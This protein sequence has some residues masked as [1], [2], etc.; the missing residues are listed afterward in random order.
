M[1]LCLRA[2][3]RVCVRV[4]VCVCVCACVRACVRGVRA[5]VRVC[6]C[7]CVCVCMCVCVYVWVWV[8]VSLH[9]MKQIVTLLNL[10][11]FI[12][13]FYTWL[14]VIFV[15]CCMN[16]NFT[17]ANPGAFNPFTAPACKISGLKSMP[18]NSRS[19]GPATNLL[20]ILCILIEAILHV[21][22]QRKTENLND[23]NLAP[24]LVV[25]RVTARQA[26]Q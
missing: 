22:A 3:V 13:N 15:M 10:S 21:H 2:C 20:S 11:L 9:C 24:L 18:A 4:C 17:R 23:S 7:V 5:C 1:Q 8:G 16:G 25:F 12:Y 6:V 26:W 14:I 19:D